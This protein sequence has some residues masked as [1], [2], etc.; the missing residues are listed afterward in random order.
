MNGNWTVKLQVILLSAY[1]SRNKLC[2]QTFKASSEE[3][4]VMGSEKMKAKC[5]KEDVLKSFFSY[6][7]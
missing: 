7:G 2:S 5:M 3:T 6:A 4:I 1:I